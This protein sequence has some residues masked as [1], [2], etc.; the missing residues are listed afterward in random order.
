MYWNPDARALV[1]LQC[2]H[3]N[4]ILVPAFYRYLQAQNSSAQIECGKEFLT[5][6]EQLV[7]LFERAE[8]EQ[9]STAVGLWNEGGQLGRADIM[10]GPCRCP[11]ALYS[12]IS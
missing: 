10:A 6:I 5:S 9:E 2:D 3:I 8:Q 4:R 1:R 11:L 7:A 12:G